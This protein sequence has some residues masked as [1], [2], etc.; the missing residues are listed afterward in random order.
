M[1][2]LEAHAMLVIEPATHIDR[3]RVRPFRRADG[4]APQIPGDPDLA[5]LVHVERGKAEQ[6]G[7]DDRQ[8]DDVGVLP[9]KLSDGL[10][11]RELAHLPFAVEGEAREY[12]VM[13]EHKPGVLD[14]L[15]PD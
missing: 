12:L 7:A 2:V 4:L 13:A 9:R 15:G 11:E 5:F 10:R 8:A 14:A 1:D 6:P 3:R